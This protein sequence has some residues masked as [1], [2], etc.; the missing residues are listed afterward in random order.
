MANVAGAVR[1]WVPDLAHSS[2]G[3]VA[4]HMV[5]T[6]VRGTF[7]KFSAKIEI[8]DGSLIP[9]SIV[10]VIEVESINTREPQRDT[11]LRSADFFD[12]AGHTMIHFKSESIEA[13]GDNDFEVQGL[14]TIRNVTKNVSFGGHAEALGKDP[15][16]NSRI[17]FEASLRINREDFGLTW[18]QTLE[19]GGVLVGKNIDIELDIQAV[20]APQQ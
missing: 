4:R 9:S 10:A 12:A 20:P 3:F 8:P 11:H 17:G 16:G 5:V 1:T 6:K 14:L 18:N 7:D 13:A 15:W 2:V 19:T